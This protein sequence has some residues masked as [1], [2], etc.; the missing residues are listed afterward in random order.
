M[1]AGAGAGAGAWTGRNGGGGCYRGGMNSAWLTWSRVPCLALALFACQRENPAFDPDVGGADGG[2]EGNG[3]A[4]TTQSSTT[5]TTTGDGDGDA[6]DGDGDADAGDG[7]GDGDPSMDGPTDSGM[8]DPLEPDMPVA[9]CMVGTHE[10]LGPRF[11]APSQ[12]QGSACQ[13]EIGMFVRVVG[14]FGDHWLASP[15]PT[16]C[17]GLCNLLTQHVVGVDGL[18]DGIATLFPPTIFNQNTPWLGCY[19][20]EAE[21]LVKETDDAC[22]YASLSAH[23]HEG[24][25]SP[26]LFNANRDS[27]G[28]TPG[29]AT[30]YNDWA[31]EIE[32]TDMSCACDLLDIDCC[33]GSTVVAKQFWL[34]DPVPPGEVG[35]IILDQT[36]F[37]FYAAQAQGGT[38]CEID[39]ETSWALWEQQ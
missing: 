21:Q 14:S 24:S 32:D 3:E 23:T 17:Y 25:N 31:P 5:P 16:G 28:L 2:S 27:W 15:C 1:G 30:H 9:E 18:P 36:P 10:G 34:D 7:D 37:T 33:M 11:G 38:H 35:E 26:L 8:E 4:S 29:A 19:Y 20:V 13:P 6:G 39:P 12:F 22:V